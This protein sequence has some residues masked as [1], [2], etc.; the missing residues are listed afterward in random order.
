L[1]SDRIRKAT[2]EGIV[3]FF[4]HSFTCRDGLMMD[5]AWQPK[6]VNYTSEFR[7]R[8]GAATNELRMRNETMRTIVF[9]SITKLQSAI[10]YKTVDL[11]FLL[12]EVS[13]LRYFVPVSCYRLITRYSETTSILNVVLRYR[14]QIWLYLVTSLFFRRRRRRRRRIKTQSS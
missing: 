10:F 6:Y 1:P 5:N 13:V 3:H 14:L 12:A 9:I 7:E 11:P 8:F 4:I 2:K